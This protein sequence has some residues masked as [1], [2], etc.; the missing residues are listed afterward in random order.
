MPTV[1]SIV[2]RLQKLPSSKWYLDARHLA[3]LLD[4]SV[5]HLDSFLKCIASG[6]VGKKSDD[7]WIPNPAP[8]KTP[9]C[10][11]ILNLH[12]ADVGRKSNASEEVSEPS[13]SVVE[14]K[15]TFARLGRV[16]LHDKAI[17]PRVQREI[18]RYVIGTHQILIRQYPK[19]AKI[20]Q[21]NWLNWVNG[22]QGSAMY[23]ATQLPYI[24]SAFQN[25]W[26]A[27]VEDVT[28]ISPTILDL[29]KN[30]VLDLLACMFIIPIPTC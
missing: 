26:N 23:Q 2:E 11:N 16:H 28:N 14:E 30:E 18:V 27:P 4:I 22:G 21:E 19:L 13:C 1:L 7:S 6:G 24:A 8:Y 25:V 9:D 10:D 15:C 12:C 20:R 29:V 3:E 17:T 5:G